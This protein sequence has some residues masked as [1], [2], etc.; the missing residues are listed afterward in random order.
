[1]GAEGKTMDGGM[2]QRKRKKVRSKGMRVRRQEGGRDEESR[3]RDG[4]N[5]PTSKK[6]NEIENSNRGNTRRRHEVEH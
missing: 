5:V 3:Q 2:V 6:D 4:H 1:M